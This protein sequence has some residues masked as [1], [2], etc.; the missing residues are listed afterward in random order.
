[1]CMNV[2]KPLPF[3]FETN[4]VN[5]VLMNV[6]LWMLIDS[7]PSVVFEH[8]FILFFRQ[9]RESISNTLNISL[10]CM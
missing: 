5:N 8:S 10:H 9:L 6:S 2:S 7:M 3:A 4:T 1:M